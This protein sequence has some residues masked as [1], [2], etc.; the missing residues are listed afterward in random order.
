METTSFIICPICLE[1]SHQSL[2]KKHL[3]KH[4]YISVEGFLKDYPHQLMETEK[5]KLAK[6]KLSKKAN[7]RFGDPIKR[8]EFRKSVCH[9]IS[10][11]VKRKLSNSIKET[12]SDP[13]IKK[14]MYT[15]ERNEKISKKKY[16]YWKNNP[17]EKIRVGNIWKTLRKRDESGWRKH[18]LKISPFGTAAAMGKKNSSLEI[19]YYNMLKQEGFSFIPQ[20]ELDGKL[21]DAFLEDRKILLEFDGSFW[22]K[23]K[24]EDCK[25]SYQKHNYLNDIEKNE[26]ANRNG[27]KLIRIREDTPIDSI[28]ELLSDIYNQ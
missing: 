18:L 4:G 28:K 27:L 22:H 11:E 3:K 17:E 10:D 19:K 5:W 16:E 13:E 14:K 2:S 7:I 1:K 12:L 25:Y 8:E 24:L 21:Y 26:I 20:Y 23:E 6:E 9:P 15:K